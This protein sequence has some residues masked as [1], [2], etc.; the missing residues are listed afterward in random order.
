MA[1]FQ[2]GEKAREEQG[3][4]GG[5]GRAQRCQRKSSTMGW[6]WLLGSQAGLEGAGGSEPN[7]DPPSQKISRAGTP[8]Q[9]EGEQHIQNPGDDRAIAKNPQ[10]H[11]HKLLHTF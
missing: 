3:E 2:E 10:S 5:V 1:L 6:T 4:R 8:G 11:G 7:P 9:T